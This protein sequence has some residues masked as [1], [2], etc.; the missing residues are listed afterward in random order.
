MKVIVVGAGVAG[1]TTA[2]S[3]ARRGH[4]VVVIDRMSGPGLDASRG[5]AGQLSYSFVSPFA[6][7]TLLKTAIKG[8][9]NAQG[10]LKIS[11][12][13]SLFTLQFLTMAFDFALQPSL[14]HD[15]RAAMLNLAQYSRAQMRRID[16]EL[17][18]SYDQAQLGLMALASSKERKQQLHQ[19]AEL[20]SQLKIDHEWLSPEQARA[21]EPGL[22]GRA[23]LHGAMLLPNDGTGDSRQFCHELAQ[24]CL[25]RGVECRYQTEVT[26][27]DVK[28]GRITGLRVRDFS[29]HQD[30]HEEG[31]TGYLQADQVV[32]AAGC[33]ARPLARMLGLSLP[34][35]PVK[36]YALTAP[37]LDADQAPRSTL[38]DDHAMLTISRLGERVRITGFMA[39]EGQQRHL[40]DSRLSVLR[41][42][43][44]ARFPSGADLTLA[45]AWAGFRPMLPDGP[46]A[47]GRVAAYDNLLIN[48]GH[49]TFGWTLAAGCAELVA[50]IAEEKTAE[51]DA[52]AFRADRFMP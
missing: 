3:L 47:L 20:L 2:W 43:F 1:L 52:T 14:F 40:R 5:S 17:S 21:R 12:P 46:P 6:D 38:L 7:P 28:R 31:S 30:V 41:S 50:D 33:G 44:Q 24:A 19:Q 22:Q 48:A 45:K 4:Q 36:G 8:L 25:A 18:L 37:V 39:L 15:N 32:L 9:T 16:K 35:Y 27:W 23:A 13:P 11:M 29:V 10:P 34:I 42:G 26:G 51:L 49:G